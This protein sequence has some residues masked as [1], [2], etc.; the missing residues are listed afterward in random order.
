MTLGKPLE[1]PK[2]D[3]VGGLKGW[4]GPVV[5][6]EVVAA[7]GLRQVELARFYQQMKATSSFPRLKIPLRLKRGNRLRGEGIRLEETGGSELQA[8]GWDHFI[9]FVIEAH[10]ILS[11]T[12]GKESN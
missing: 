8:G 4:V 7:E 3:C 12:S 1:I 9:C 5:V 6:G 11:P 2:R 10:N